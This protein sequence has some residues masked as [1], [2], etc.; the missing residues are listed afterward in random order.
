MHTGHTRNRWQ[1]TSGWFLVFLLLSST[2]TIGLLPQ[3]AGA[4]SLGAASPRLTSQPARNPAST[5]G[6]NTPTISPTPNEGPV[7]S[8]VTLQGTDWPPDSQLI[9]GYDSDSTCTDANFTE[10]SPDPKPTV[11][12]TGTF[13]ATFSWPAV[14]ATGL[15]YICAATSDQTTTGSTAFNV[16]SL[17]PP[18]L[19]I[20]TQGPFMPGQAMTVQ[21]KN[22]LPG[23]WNIS[24]ALQPAQ[25]TGSFPLEETAISLFNGTFD[26]LS[27]TIP[28][29]I[30]PGSYI[31]V[32]TMEQQ[33]LQAASKPITINAPPTPTPTAT[34]LPSPTPHVTVTPTPGNK[35][36]TT[37]SAPHRLS[38]TLL[39]LV[40]ISGSMALSFALIGT[41][42]LLYLRRRHTP[43]STPL[44]L[45]Q[46]EETGTLKP[47]S[48][49]Q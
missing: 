40:V 23:G 33:A 9:I 31:L 19:T 4:R 1:R 49:G 6:S 12:S 13:S 14:S 26:P 10:L 35:H 42:L 11:S 28:L 47:R 34:I 5:P 20:Q 48:S 38:G 41:V 3:G 24:F 18:S 2:A 29:Y 30:Q 37:P 46:Y 17:S 45:E 39:A 27:I 16:L 8:L 22:W 15:W 25:S 21:G 32:A 7:S 43:P 44:A 36:Q